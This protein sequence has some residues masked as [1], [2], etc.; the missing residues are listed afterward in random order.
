MDDENL[1]Q[2]RWFLSIV[3]LILALPGNGEM[4]SGVDVP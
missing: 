2:L 4:G 3:I 1:V